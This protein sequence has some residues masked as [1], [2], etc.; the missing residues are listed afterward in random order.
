MPSGVPGGGGGGGGGCSGEGRGGGCRELVIRVE[1]FQQ[2][3]LI[4][5]GVLTAGMWGVGC[6]VG[7]G[8]EGM[9]RGLDDEVIILIGS[10]R[11]G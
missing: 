9:G 5:Q 4:S 8:R 6:G 11:G 10:S 2:S 7:G 3:L 1:C